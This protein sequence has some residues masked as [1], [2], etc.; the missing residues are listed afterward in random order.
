MRYS[1]RVS[2]SILDS[3]GMISADFLFAL[4]LCVGLTIVL[5]AL[6]FTLSMAEVA[7]YIAFSSARAHAAGHINQQAQEDLAKNKYN[8]LINHPVLSNLF[9]S[10]GNGWFQLSNFEV[11]G[12][13]PS[14]SVFDDYPS[15]QDRVPQ[16][17]VRF[18]FTS[19]LLAIKVPFLGF[20]SEDGEGAGFSSKVTGFLIR[21]P[22]QEE[23]WNL[24]IKP[25]YDAILNLD[26]RF[27]T[28]G[29]AGK[30][31]YT[32]MEDNGC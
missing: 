12:A 5:F 21:E 4:V 30:S 28:L 3:R 19:K 18:S 20:T 29:D 11:R 17:G 25:R 23:C 2:K 14:G 32:P 24:Q 1:P 13:G 15:D 26:P 6:N 16:V 10:K 27:R 9:G 31:K 22:T 7:Q 8:A